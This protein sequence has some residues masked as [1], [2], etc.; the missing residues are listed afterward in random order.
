MQAHGPNFTR[1]P[2]DLI[3]GEEEYKIERIIAHRHFGRSKRLQYL[4]KWKGYP[5]SDNTW[6]PADQVHAPE[7]IKHYKSAAHHQSAAKSA[8]QSATLPAGI[9]TLQLA[10]QSCIKCPMIFPASLSNASQ[11]TSLSKNSPHSN[12][13][14][15]TSTPPNPAHIAYSTSATSSTHPTYQY[16]TGIV[17]SPTA[18]FITATRACQISLA[19]TP[20]NPPAPPSMA[21]LLPLLLS[22]HLLKSSPQCSQ[23]SLPRVPDTLDSLLLLPMLQDPQDPQLPPTISL[24]SDKCPP[25][26]SAAPL[27]AT[28]SQPTPT[29]P[30][31]MDWLS[32]QKRGPIASPKIWLPKKW[33]SRRNWMT[34]TKPSSSW[35]PISSGISKCS[36]NPL[37]GTS[38]TVIF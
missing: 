27:P 34:M 10:P 26:Q 11:K 33:S 14:N 25:A 35:R 32:L 22:I 4:I 2:P 13:P 9:R 31:S 30:L 19:M 23:G 21:D 38:K 15:T 20:Q 8:H 24:P 7:L 28:T 17:N 29:G 36:P 3:N 6:E 37:M 12:I 18:P 16:I 1:P 5:K